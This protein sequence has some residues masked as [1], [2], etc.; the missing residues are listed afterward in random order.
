VAALLP[1]SAK[2]LVEKAWNSYPTCRTEYSNPFLGDRFQIIVQSVHLPDNGST[3]N[4]HNLTPDQLAMRQVVH[5]DIGKD[6]VNAPMKPNTDPATFKSEKT[7]R[8]PLTEGWKDRAEPV[9]CCYKLITIKFQVFGFQTK[10]ESLI[11]ANQI[12]L[13]TK[14]HKEIFC[15]IDRWHGLTMQDIRR[16]ED[17]VKDE[18]AR[19]MAMQ[20]GFSGI[21]HPIFIL[22]LIFLFRSRYTCSRV[23]QVHALLKSRLIHT[24][25]RIIMLSW[26]QL[27]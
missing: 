11:Q 24:I 16:L 10:V 20:E 13:L 14:F 17:E 3:E 22:L 8:G 1:T 27:M 5:V 12:D 2:Q 15:A 9:M 23:R 6:P 19:K 18:L 26:K 7:G 25:S 4:A 21:F